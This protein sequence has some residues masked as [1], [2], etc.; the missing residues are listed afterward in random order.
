[1]NIVQGTD[2]LNKNK[3]QLLEVDAVSKDLIDQSGEYIIEGFSSC[4]KTQRYPKAIPDGIVQ[5]NPTATKKGFELSN[6]EASV[7]LQN[8]NG[9]ERYSILT[10]QL[11]RLLAQYKDIHGQLVSATDTYLDDR[12]VDRNVYAGFIDEFKD[13]VKY[14]GC[15]NDVAS[16]RLIPNLQRNYNATQVFSIDS[17]ARRAWDRGHTVFGVQ[18]VQNDSKSALCYT[19]TDLEL[20]KRD[21]IGLSFPWTWASTQTYGW[22]KV[23]SANAKLQLFQ[24]GNLVLYEGEKADSENDFTLYSGWNWYV[25]RWGT[26]FASKN[27]RNVRGQTSSDKYSFFRYWEWN[28]GQQYGY[29][30]VNY[31]DR[32]YVGIGWGSLSRA[33]VYRPNWWSLSYWIR[34]VGLN[35]PTISNK[36]KYTDWVSASIGNNN[37]DT[38]RLSEIGMNCDKNETLSNF[39]LES[40]TDGYKSSGYYRQS[41]IDYPG[42]DYG[43]FRNWNVNQ[44]QSWCDKRDGCI[45]FNIDKRRGGCW[46]KYSW[47]RYSRNRKLD[48]YWRYRIPNYKMRYWYQCNKSE[49]DLTCR[50][51]YT[52]WNDA[53][54]GNTIYLDRHNVNCNEN[55][56]I[57]AMNLE[58]DGNKMRYRYTCCKNTNTDGCFMIMQDDGNL[59][60]YK[61]L[62]PENKKDMM[63]SSRTS[64]QAGNMRIQKWL[65]GRKNNRNYMKTGEFLVPGEYICNDAGT[66]KAEFQADGNFVIRKSESRCKPIR[67]KQYGLRGGNA[68]YTIP[69]NNVDDLNKAVYIDKAENLHNIPANMMEGGKEF[70][71]LENTD[72]WGN[73]I[74]EVSINND[75]A[76]YGEYDCQS[77]LDRYPDLRRAFGNSCTDP[78]TA[79]KAKEHWERHGQAEGRKAGKSGKDVFECEKAC[80]EDPNCGSFVNRDDKCWLKNKNAFPVGDRQRNMGS[81][82]YIRSKYANNDSSCTSKVEA[83]S[84]T[85]YS[86]I[87]KGLGG[88]GRPVD[89]MN[90]NSACGLK[91][92]TEQERKMLATK[93]RDIEIKIQDILKEMDTLTKSGQAY[94]EQKPIVKQNMNRMIDEY[95]KSFKD[96]AKYRKSR[97]MINTFE[98][99]SD[100]TMTSDNYRYVLWSV[101]AIAVLIAVIQI[102]KNRSV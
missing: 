95:N 72:S 37:A 16:E 40:K 74:R 98:D 59:V 90:K 87:M 58:V 17:C 97:D 20:A 94:L 9:E 56:A 34:I 5:S 10:D 55:E 8:K 47:G 82:L 48:F 4:K 91:R 29:G 26:Q 36:T 19:G 93:G 27:G 44:C 84:T 49:G 65:D 88:D 100:L 31:L 78:E 42:N 69:K 53:G 83:V 14:E 67:G 3:K 6:E 57:G 41:G 39:K 75:K 11:T 79:R 96:I 89:T 23:N 73:D 80:I 71:K 76:E 68:V 7:D 81:D 43:Y 15:F 64:G 51:T 35:V 1:M 28:R 38:R 22:P 30:G 63:W 18:N 12:D 25:W 62:N 101:G 61:G 86:K 70:V 2:Y 85:E 50:T 77:Y 66:A 45:G 52:N 60:I 92:D 33:T 32:Q 24:N 21:G 46:I 99:N 54:G 102:M 13:E